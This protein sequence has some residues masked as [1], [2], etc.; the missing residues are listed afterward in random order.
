MATG[1][2]KTIAAMAVIEW[3]CA[4]ASQNPVLVI[5][6]V[7]FLNLA[8]Q[9]GKEFIRWGHRPVLCARGR[10][11]WLSAAQ[12]LIHLLNRKQS[13]FGCL[14]T[15]NATF[16]SPPFQE[17]LEEIQSQKLHMLLL[18]DEVHNLGAKKLRKALPE[19]AQYRLGLSATP[20]RWCDPD[21]TAAIQ[22][23]FGEQ[24]AEFTLADAL[25]AKPPVLCP[26]DYYPVVVELEEDEV[27]S[28]IELSTKIAQ[29]LAIS[30]TRARDENDPLLHLLIKRSRLL[31]SARQKIPTLVQLMARHQDQSHTLIYCGDGRAE[32]EAVP[33]NDTMD[34]AGEPLEMR[35]VEAAA[36]AL[37]QSFEMEVSTY[38]AATSATD[39]KSRLTRFENGEL[40][41]LVAIKCL[42]E[43]VDIPMIRRA[44]ILASSTNPR[45]FIQR[46]GRILRRASGKDYAEL[47]DFVVAPPNFE[48][49]GV[50]DQA[51]R[52]AL[53]RMVKREMIRVLEFASTARNHY[54]ARES[55]S[56]LLAR[57]DLAHL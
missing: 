35:Q 14:L 18:G 5:V 22:D 8:D 57:L 19:Q 12:G 33:K 51:E 44:F 25:K 38:T 53:K 26:Y 47:Y 49:L 31:A 7:P 36:A 55:L 42:D 41:A 15:S 21:G 30:G 29:L 28:Y 37:R 46:R 9:W 23:Y 43:G 48:R 27:E 11:R 24:V 50:T 32:L 40:Q 10:N 4:Q 52:L 56:E 6:V 20:E 16:S 39:R 2:G 45:Q 34:Q 17:L 13:S 54:Q 3:L 1:A